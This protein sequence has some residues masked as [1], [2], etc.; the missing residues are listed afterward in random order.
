MLGKA[1]LESRLKVL[2]QCGRP[3]LPRTTEAEAMKDELQALDIGV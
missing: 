2:F 3:H 1:W